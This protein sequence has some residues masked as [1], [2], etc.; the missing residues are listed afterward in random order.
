MTC[1][2]RPCLAAGKMMLGALA[3]ALTLLHL[4]SA[5]AEEHQLYTSSG[6]IDFEEVYYFAQRASN[7]YKAD[8]AINTL[9]PGV[10]WIATPGTTDVL[11]FI[12]HD[13]DS[14]IHTISVRG[15]ASK[16]NWSL[17][18]DTAGIVDAKAHILVHR[19]FQSAAKM[20]YADL[21]QHLNRDYSVYLTG[22]SLGGAVAGLLA[23]Y[24]HE[25]G[26]KIAGVVTF[27][28][29]K[30]TNEAGI[31]EY[32][33]LPYLRVVDQNDI[34][35]M[36]P[37]TTKGGQ[38]KFAHLGTEVTILSGP[39]YAFLAPSEATKLSLESFEHDAV[40]SSVPDHKIDW[41]LAN[42]KDKLQRAQRV[43]YADRETYVVRHTR[44]PEQQ[45]QQ[46]TN[47]NSQQ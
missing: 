12:E 41:Y 7:A 9:D 26:Y 17:D 16:A 28:Q 40:L 3:L 5:Y 43:D 24:L 13:H 23:L 27:G 14:R 39:Y 21:K 33:H 2:M 30:F 46:K 29:P 10:S 37:D 4:P 15:T 8:A 47:F 31:A 36:L 18:E 11:Y 44:G 25:D 32:G 45:L 22:H 6:E 38:V 42:I 20:L 19:G 1:G 35:P 34:V